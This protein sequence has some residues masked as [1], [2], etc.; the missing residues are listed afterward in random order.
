MFRKI[1]V[2]LDGSDGG[3]LALTRAIDMVRLTGGT[4][5]VISV[6]ERVPAY[7]ATVGEVEDA[8]RFENQYFRPIHAE[9]EALAARDGIALTHEIVPGHA[10]H[11]IVRRAAEGAFD[12]IVLGHT[13]HSRLHVMLLGSTPDRV[14]E[15]APCSVLVV[16]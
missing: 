4:I 12:L 2:G 10:A 1:L 3:H 14:V 6:E 13:G 5:H 9:A 7:A 8:Q 15:H 11:I 16:R